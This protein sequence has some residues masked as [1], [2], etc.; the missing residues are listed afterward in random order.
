[1][2]NIA[3]VL[4]AG[5]GKRMKSI[6]PKQFLV[7][8]KEQM[9]MKSLHV[10]EKSDIIDEIVLVTN[11]DKIKEIKKL[12]KKKGDCHKVKKVI[13]GGPHRWASVYEGLKVCDNCRYVFIH[14]S[15]RPYVTADI[16]KRAY[17]AV[18]EFGAVAVGMPSKDTVKIVDDD[19]F[20]AETP[21]RS[22]VWTIQTPQ[23]FRYQMIKE[24]YDKLI[25]ADDMEGITDDA[26]VMERSGLSRVKVVEGAYDNLKIT[27][28]DD[29]GKAKAKEEPNMAEEAKK[30]Q[31]ALDKAAEKEK[32]ADG[33]KE[34]K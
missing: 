5:Q 21:V 10:F 17:K 19:G 33:K 31:K 34:K 16:I 29:W 26:M 32:K 1:M 13:S 7:M 25:A 2:K 23:T 3:I 18:K 30:A 20:V 22:H 9:L 6:V 4:A 14:D 12:V 15:A 24:A 8:G 28:P 27:T 11:E